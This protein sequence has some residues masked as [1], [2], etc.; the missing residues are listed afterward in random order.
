LDELEVM[1]VAEEGLLR[2]L[3]ESTPL[4]GLGITPQL[5]Q[6][7][8]VVELTQEQLRDMLLRD[9]DPRAKSSVTLEL[10]EGKLILKIRLW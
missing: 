6:R 7:D 8:I 4:K 9:A 2:G 10:K 1:N 3:L 5:T